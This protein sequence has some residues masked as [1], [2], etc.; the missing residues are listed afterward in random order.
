MLFSQENI[1]DIYEYVN[2]FDKYD[3]IIW[4]QF[5]SMVQEIHVYFRLRFS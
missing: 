4:L 3:W 5:S 1:S 2:E